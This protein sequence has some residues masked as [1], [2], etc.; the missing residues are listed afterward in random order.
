MV[1]FSP[2]VGQG[3][4]VTP[5]CGPE[6]LGRTSLRLMSEGGQNRS[7]R[8][9]QEAPPTPGKESI[10][11]GVREGYR[12]SLNP[13]STRTGLAILLVTI[14][15][16]ACLSPYL[17]RM[18][19]PSIYADDV[20]R[21]ADLQRNP[22]SRLLIRPFNE[23]LAP[24]TELVSW[25]AWHASGKNFGRARWTFTYVSPVPFV[26]NMALLYLILRRELKSTTASL[27][28][29][30]VFAL[31]ALSIETVLWFSAS[32]FAWSM[33]GTLAAFWAAGADKRYMAF[34]CSAMA[35]GFSA[36]GLLAGPFAACRIGFVSEPVPFRKRVIGAAFPLLGTA[37]YLGLTLPFR[38]QSILIES[39]HKNADFRVGLTYACRAPFGVLLPALIGR[40]PLAML[41]T[42]GGWDVVLA[43]VSTLLLVGL[44]WRSPHRPLILCGLVLI[45]GGYGLT[46]A[47]RTNQGIHQMLNVQRYHLFPQIGLIFILAPLLVN[48][49]KLS[50]RKQL[51]SLAVGA[52]F[53]VLLCRVQGP[54]MKGKVNY[55]RFAEQAATLAVY[56]QIAQTCRSEHI[57]RA[58]ALEALEPVRASW[59]PFDISP[60]MML[61]E[62]VGATEWSSWQVR[63]RLLSGLTDQH[64]EALYGNMQVTRILVKVEKDVPPLGIATLVTSLRVKPKESERTYESAGW[65]SFLEFDLGPEVANAKYFCLPGVEAKDM[66][67]WWASP[68][69]PWTEAHSIRWGQKGTDPHEAWAVELAKLPHWHSEHARRVRLMFRSPGPVAVESPRLFR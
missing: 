28:A 66:E 50:D 36:I 8:K 30:A 60:L 21:I 12:V 9:S 15:L 27:I 56:D 40:P 19:S 37:S 49:C 22:L 25:W 16:V 61:P 38:Y 64:V 5:M 47:V 2:Q 46:Y 39:L 24:L 55:Y 59:F 3:L 43:A 54:A 10:H 17:P 20:V 13:K 52:L 45:S 34:A 62:T 35:P 58:Q 26:L 4:P 57:S 33:V 63:S 41:G 44:A 32:T 53:A 18:M 51:R 42:P 14:F 1:P 6:N 23:H 31:S 67:V 65:P 48:I 69:E 7:S 68:G 11:R 29:V